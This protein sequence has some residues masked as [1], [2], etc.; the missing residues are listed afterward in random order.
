MY[1]QLEVHQNMLKLYVK[2][3]LKLKVLTTCFDFK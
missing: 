2:V 1:V 3:M